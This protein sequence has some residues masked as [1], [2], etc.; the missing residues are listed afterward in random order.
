[1]TALLL[2]D[3]AARLMRRTGVDQLSALLFAIDI[4]VVRRGGAISLADVY[5]G[6]TDPLPMLKLFGKQIQPR[7]V[8]HADVRRWIGD[9]LRS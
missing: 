9:L 7:M 4:D 3:V 5:G 6:M 8:G 2:R 1:V